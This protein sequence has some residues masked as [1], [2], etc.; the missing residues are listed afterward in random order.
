MSETAVA[1]PAEW[2]DIFDTLDAM[3]PDELRALADHILAL[4]A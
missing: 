4:L 3:T 1:A 2:Q